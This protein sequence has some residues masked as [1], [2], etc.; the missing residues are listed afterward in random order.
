MLNNTNF[1][2]K[3]R[4]KGKSIISID[5]FDKR[6]ILM[7]MNEAKKIKKMSPVKRASVLKHKMVTLLFYEP[8]SRTFSS[9]SAAI[10]KLGGLTVEY[11]NPTQTSSAVKGETIA[12]TV[13]VFEH[14]SDA[15]VIRHPQ[16]GIPQQAAEATLHIPVI[17]AGDGIGEH[18]TQA[19]LDLFTIFQRHKKLNNLKGLLVG[20]LLNGRTVHSLIR[21]FSKFSHNT[22]YLLAPKKLRLIPRDLEMFRKANIHLIYISTLQ[23]IPPDCHFWYWTRVQKERFSS[24][25]E[26]EKL[27]KT[28]ILT[29]QLLKEK[30][31]R[32]LICMHPLPRVGEI[33]PEVDNDP[34]A[35]YLRDEVHNGLIVRMALLKLVLK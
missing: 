7:V 34:R 11:Q 3:S 10:K 1:L 33:D 21:A 30:G 18:P 31:N 4:F 32:N 28:Y 9:F 19:L 5:Q 25:K 16:Q 35:V 29:S 2:I 15:I 27:K 17:N 22:L 23:E 26:Y 13:R 14:Y 24:L 8:S 12:D 6:S 20:D